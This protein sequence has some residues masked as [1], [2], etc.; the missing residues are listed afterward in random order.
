MSLE[1]ISSKNKQLTPTSH[2]K[3]THLT[4][5]CVNV[6][7]LVDRFYVKT[8]LTDVIYEHCSKLSYNISKAK[9][10]NH[11]SVLKQPINLG[12]FLQRSE[13]TG[14]R[15]E[16]CKHKTKIY[17]TLQYSMYFSDKHDEVVYIMIS[18]KIHVGKDMDIGH[19]VWDILD[20]NT[21]TW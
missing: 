14:V 6:K 21:G 17:L 18:I 9:F 1:V 4:N 19:Y 12:I 3:M 5:N 7:E 15:Y 20:Y 11:Q 13:Y 10:E 16:Y 2:E 8:E